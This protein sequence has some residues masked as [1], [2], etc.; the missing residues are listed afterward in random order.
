M[1]CLARAARWMAVAALLAVIAG[2][3][4][5]NAPLRV[6]LQSWPPFEYLHLAREKGFFEAEGVDVRLIEFVEASDAFRAY[7]HGKLDGGTFS[8]MQVLRVRDSSRL[9]LQI[10][11]ITDYSDGQDAILARTGIDNVPGLRGKRVGVS[12][13]PLTVYMLARALELH[14]MTLEDVT[15][16]RILDTNTTA[17]LRSGLID[18]VIT[19]PPRRLQVEQ[20]AMA[21]PIFTSKDI[22]GEIVDALAFQESIFKER[23]QDVARV[24]RAFHRAVRYTAEQPDE[25]MRIMAERE[26]VDPETFR[27]SLTDGLTVAA[28]A[29]QQ[30]LLAPD[31]PL[32]QVIQRIAA[33]M[34]ELGVLSTAQYGGEVLNPQGAALAVAP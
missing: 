11:M 13:A 2:C 17:S 6:G 26:K 23:P 14:G 31:S 24:I 4:R 7:D 20:E 34:H 22:P 19:Y 8:L 18:A 30:H 28:L 9:K 29:D 33:T 27:K 3:G 10:A 15:L 1:N 5:Q 25:A 21:H 12:E 16:V 32:A